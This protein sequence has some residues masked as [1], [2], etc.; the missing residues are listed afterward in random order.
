MS[1]NQAGIV[2]LED[3][4]TEQEDG[5]L[6]KPGKT[7]FWMKI[8]LPFSV[9]VVDLSGPCLGILT[10]ARHAITGKLLMLISDKNKREFLVDNLRKMGFYDAI[11]IFN[12]A[13]RETLVLVNESTS[14]RWCTFIWPQKKRGHNEGLRVLHT[15]PLISFDHRKQSIV[16]PCV[17]LLISDLNQ[18]GLYSYTTQVTRF[19]TQ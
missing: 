9:V 14:G 19:S 8:E 18:L 16:H 1:Q 13:C 17:T 7:T 15:P 12:R 4:L 5:M 10:S 3:Q 11:Y 6:T 2:H